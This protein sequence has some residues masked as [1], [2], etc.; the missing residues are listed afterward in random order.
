MSV[1]QR[2]Q[3][4]RRLLCLLLSVSQ[5]APYYMLM[6]KTFILLMLSVSGT[7]KDIFHIIHILSP[8]HKS[9]R[10]IY[11]EHCYCV[12][13]ASAQASLGFVL[14]SDILFGTKVWIWIIIVWVI[15][16]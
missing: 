12:V 4:E 8:F 13:S 11:K 6:H 16:N 7:F 3:Y 2:C 10:V 9:A 15:I 14:V 5:A 1:T